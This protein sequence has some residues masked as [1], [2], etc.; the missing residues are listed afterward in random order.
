MDRRPSGGDPLFSQNQQFLIECIG[1]RP[2]APT[3]GGVSD[4]AEQLFRR[5][6]QSLLEDLP[7]VDTLFRTMQGKYTPHGKD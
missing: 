1:C 2:C 3:N 6:R 4:G 7:K 5:F